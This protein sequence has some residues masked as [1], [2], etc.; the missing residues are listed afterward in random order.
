MFPNGVS[1]RDVL[2]FETLYG[3][4]IGAITTSLAVYKVLNEVD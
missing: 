2:L 4:L 3:T 1:L